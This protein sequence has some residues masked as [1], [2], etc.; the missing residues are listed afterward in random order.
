MTD[1]DCC[2]STEVST[3]A[4]SDGTDHGGHALAATDADPMARPLPEEVGRALGE[5]YGAERPAGTVGD[6]VAAVRD[7]LDGTEWMPP[8]VGDLCHDAEGRHVARN[9]DQSF[10]F[11][12]V[13]D[14]FVLQALVDAAV[15]VESTPPGG[16]EV[17][18]TVTADGVD[19]DP[20]TAVLSVG[21]AADPDVPD[22]PTPAAVYG[23]LC[24]Y[25][26]AFPSREAYREWDAATPEGATTAL[27]L[28]AARD[29][30]AALVEPS[31]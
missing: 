12:C 26:H 5:V 24:P 30:A 9:P 1:C 7:A 6:W 23:Q 10:R 17:R 25:V 15:T 14:A 29:L 20:G 8:S 31:D 27:P 21:A 22:E 3:G 28:T 18:A 2:G 4:T 11:V 19:A 16:G 13:L